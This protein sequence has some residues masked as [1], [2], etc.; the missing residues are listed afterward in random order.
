MRLDAIARGVVPE[1][2]V[3]DRDDHVVAGARRGTVRARGHA[4]AIAR[5]G[6]RSVAGAARATAPSAT[7]RA[8]GTC[9]A[10]ALAAAARASVSATARS[11]AALHRAAAAAG[12][13]L[14]RVHALAA[15]TASAGEHEHQHH[16]QVP[17]CNPSHTRRGHAAADSISSRRRQARPRKS[18]RTTRLPVED[19]PRF[20]H[21]RAS[22]ASGNCAGVANMSRSKEIV[23]VAAAARGCLCRLCA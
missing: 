15:L 22:A 2:A 1:V 6:I 21:P 16:A 5:A 9:C 8:A 13:L 14:V 20:T 17:N 18:D 7:S 11:V 3:L 12:V 10:A 23:R 19:G 4:A